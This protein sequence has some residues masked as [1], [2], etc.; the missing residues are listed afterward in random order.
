MSRVTVY[1]S[2]SLA[3]EIQHALDKIA[4]SELP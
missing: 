2:K 4:A 1:K 3:V